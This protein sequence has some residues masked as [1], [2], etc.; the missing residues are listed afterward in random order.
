[1]CGPVQACADESKGAFVLFRH[2]G[3]LP[4]SLDGGV[5]RCLPG[6]RRPDRG[7]RDGQRKRGRRASA[8]AAA[9]VAAVKRAILPSHYVQRL[10][11]LNI[12]FCM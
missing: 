11:A 2:A 7:G 5:L 3:Q 8:S 4:G 1:M 9:A 10:E 6:G 12:F